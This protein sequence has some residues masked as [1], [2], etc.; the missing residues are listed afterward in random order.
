MSDTPSTA[1]AYFP[2]GTAQDGDIWMNPQGGPTYLTPNLGNWGYATIFHEFG[3]ALGLQHGHPEDVNDTLFLPPSEDNWNYSLMTYR[4]YAGAQ[5]DFVRGNTESDNPT[6]YMQNDIA[7]LQHMYGANFNTNAGNTVYRWSP[8]TGQFSVNGESWGTPLNNKIFMTV[9]DGNGVDTY[10]LS[11]Y[12]TGLVLDLRPGAFSTFSTA[13]LADL[14]GTATVRPALGN[15]ANARLYQGDPRSLIENAIGGS[16]SD[17]IIGNT[18]GNVLNGGAGN[19]VLNGGPG[20]DRLYGGTGN[21]IHYVDN[22]GDRI[23]EASTG[24]T[25]DRVYSA[26]S[27]TIA[28]YVEHLYASGSASITLKGNGSANAIVGNAGRNTIYG[29]SGNDRL[30]GGTGNDI[31]D[32]GLGRDVLSGGSGSD[33]FVLKDHRPG[34]TYYDRITDFNR[35]YDGYLRIDNKYMSKLGGTGRLSSSEFVLG[36]AA[37]DAYDRVIYDKAKGY[38]Y[39]DPDGTGGAAKQLIAWLTNKASLSYSDIYVI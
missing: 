2:S 39:Y 22:A 8:T 1:W 24:G 17:R 5:T 23:V 6:T 29:L 38:L 28:A 9:W 19:D 31:L 35:S 33:T 3:H 18:A 25:A 27:H 37:K 14:D 13:Q 12:T 21:D 20:A 16:G 30:T 36:T 4:S 34:S 15:V 10:N 26:I 7:A 11:S 32:G